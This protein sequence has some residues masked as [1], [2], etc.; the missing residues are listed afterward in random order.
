MIS[1]TKKKDFDSIFANG[2]WITPRNSEVK[3]R[4]Q[5]G[6]V[7]EVAIAIPRKSGNAVLRNKARRQV[8]ELLRYFEG[9]LGLRGQFV[10]FLQKKFVEDEFVRKKAELERTFKRFMARSN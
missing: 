10:L 8:R 9:N 3:I 2:R 4:A 5:G 6:S 1:L 7:L